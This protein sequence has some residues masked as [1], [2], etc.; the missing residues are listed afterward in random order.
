LEYKGNK[1]AA[2]INQ[3]GTSMVGRQFLVVFKFSEPSKSDMNFKYRI[4]S[5]QDF[6]D[7]L[8]KFKDNPPKP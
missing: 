6:L 3:G 7:L 5:E 2:G 8:E 1:K 4:N